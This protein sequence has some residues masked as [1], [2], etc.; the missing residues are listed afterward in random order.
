MKTKNYIR[1]INTFVLVLLANVAICQFQIQFAGLNRWSRFNPAGAQN[2]YAIGVGNFDAALGRQALASVHI[3]SFYITFPYYGAGNL[4]RTDAINSVDNVWNM[5]TG[6]TDLTKTE[7]FRLFNPAASDN[8]TFQATRPLGDMLFNTGGANLRMTIDGPTGF[9]GIGIATPNFLLHQHNSTPI[10]GFQTFHQFTTVTTGTTANDGYRIG[11]DLVNIPSIGNIFTTDAQHIQTENNPIEIFTNTNDPL[12]AGNN[13][14]GLRMRIFHTTNAAGHLVTRIGIPYENLSGNAS[15]DDNTGLNNYLVPVSLLHLGNA[16]VPGA[17]GHR[18]WMEVGTYTNYATDMAYFG[19]KQEGLPATDD[20]DA[21][22][23]WGDNDLQSVTD[24]GNVLR[25]IFTGLPGLGEASNFNGLEAARF[26]NTGYFGIGN[27]SDV[28]AGNGSGI[29]PARKL[30]IYDQ[31]QNDSRPDA[32]QL[33]LTY[34]P[35]TPPNIN[36]TGIWTDF[37]TTSLGNLRVNASNSRVGV[38]TGVG[39][40][41]QNNLEIDADATTNHHYTGGGGGISGLTFNDLASTSN[42]TFTSNLKVL[43]VNTTGDVVLTT[44]QVGTGTSTCLTNTFVQRADGTNIV[45]SVIQDN[46]TNVGVSMA[47]SGTHKFS[48]NG[49]INLNNLT[50][51]YRI[52]NEHALSMPFSLTNICVGFNAGQFLD[53][54]STNNTFVGD[55]AGEGTSLAIPNEGVNNTALGARAL[56]SNTLGNNNVAIGQSALFNNT[57]GESNMAVGLEAL[58]L[59]TTGSQN[60]AIGHASLTDN[61]DGNDNT[62]TGDHALANNEDGD[63]NTA[64]GRWSLQANTTGI[65]NTAVGYNSLFTNETGDGNTAVGAL[66]GDEMVFGGTNINCTFI[67]RDADDAFPDEG[68]LINATAIGNASRVACSDCMVLGS[69]TGGGHNQVRVGIGYTNPV[70]ANG[71]PFLLYVNS[72]DGNTTGHSAFFRG[73]IFVAGSFI[74][75]DSSLKD[76][77]QLL[78]PDT[79][80]N[81]LK[82]LVPRTYT[83]D[84]ANNPQLYLPSGLQYGLMASNVQQELPGLVKT[85]TA[86]AILDT[87][88]NVIHPELTF[89]A[90]NPTGLIPL[91]VAAVNEQGEQIESLQQQIAACCLLTPRTE[92]PATNTGSIELE[93]IKTLQLFAADPNPFSESTWVRWSIPEAFENAIIYFYDNLGNQINTYKIS[94]KGT[95]AI[96]VFGSKLS[97]GIYTYSLVVDGKVI[98]SKKMVKAK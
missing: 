44:D 35:A 21:I 66:A 93:N 47:P 18:S 89:S 57:E 54:L 33:R 88:G 26:D 30:E 65:N 82:C 29:A 79:A 51:M 13:R 11:M 84:Q 32:P 98:D 85:L 41:P 69:L 24:R 9:V 46:G 71:N 39:L 16:W 8:I 95:G 72:N 22:I 80:C 86:P 55:R 37:Q 62:A 6:A 58:L 96:Q 75:S 10:V 97:A 59:N 63:Q 2:P 25:F 31:H 56:R 34:T 49:D 23:N 4:F 94:E 36:T 61:I 27:F 1:L 19:L 91:L 76:N 68:T 87:A 14:L 12:Y 15:W 67:G 81:I 45:C 53:P 48:V 38:N 17:G 5:F 73:D 60:T 20:F 52:S 74:P 7:K 70:T 28:A 83:F 64:N 3:N 42:T 77:I 90:I 92:N 78:Q 43:T 50:R 40:E